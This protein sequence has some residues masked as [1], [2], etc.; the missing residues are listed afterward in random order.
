MG[1]RGSKGRARRALT[2]AEIANEVD[3]DVRPANKPPSVEPEP[4][5]RPAPEP[6]SGRLLDQPLS[7]NGWGY[8]PNL[9]IAYHTDGPIGTAVDRM[10]ADARMDVDGK[11]LGDVLGTVA[12][13]VVMGRRTPQE[14][15]DA[16]KEIRDR[17]PE[18]SQA[19][20]QLDSAI[21][22]VDAPAGPA[23]IVPDTVPAP[24]RDLA[25]E[26]NTIPLVRK[27]PDKEMAPLI[28][29]CQRFAAGVT[30]GR[31]VAREVEALHNGR[32]ESLGDVGKFAI[33]RA[34]QRAAKALREMPRESL[35][36]PQQGD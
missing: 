7:E 12:T 14:G 32:H 8:D 18:G 11:P 28:D 10:G 20:W 31:R 36:L 29:L 30:G 33:D 35:F 16:Y 19:R 17:L 5:T 24:L 22:R 6:V 4:P 25:H 23:P 9:P 26:L 2:D 3:R 13:D 21:Q 27:E 1:G 34:V 15:L